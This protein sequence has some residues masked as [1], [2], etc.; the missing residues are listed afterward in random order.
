[1]KMKEDRG[2]QPG[3]TLA[4]EAGPATA[5]DP[6][7]E[8]IAQGLGASP[9]AKVKTGGLSSGEGGDWLYVLTLPQLKIAVRQD[10]LRAYVNLHS[11]AELGPE[12]VQVQLAQHHLQAVEIPS[13]ARLQRRAQGNQ[14]WVKVAEGR[15]PSP[16]RAEGVELGIPG[17]LVH[18]FWAEWL[19][20]FG[21]DLPTPET[22][23]QLQGLAVLPGQFLG[24][25]S[26]EQP[27]QAGTDVFGREVKPALEPMLCGPMPGAQVRRTEEGEYLAE[28][29]GYLAVVED[30]LTVLP[31]LSM[32]AAATQVWWVVLDQRPHPVEGELV[33]QGLADLGVTM[34]I[35][36]PAIKGLAAQ[37]REGTL[38]RGCYLIAQAIPPID[39]MDAR[40]EGLAAMER[41]AS[42][43][44]F[45]QTSAAPQ[46]RAGQ[47][48]ARRLPP[49]PPLLGYD[50]L[51]RPLPGREG[52]DHPL[53]AGRNVGLRF[54]EGAEE[55]VAQVE[56]RLKV[57]G[58]QVS[59][60]RLLVIRGDVGFDTGNLDFDGM[61]HV[62]GSVIQ[63][64]SVKAGS[65]LSI[66]GAV[67][68]GAE[69]VA[70]GRLWVGKGIV[71]RRT[72]VKAREDVYTQFVQE[73]TVMAGRDIVAHS[74]AHH[75]NL[76]AGGRVVVLRTL[77]KGGGGI[78]GGQAWSLE[79]M[80]LFQAGDTSNA[81]TLLV[82]GMRP[83]QAEQLDKLARHLETSSRHIA[84][85]LNKFGLLK[86]DM[87][88]IRNLITAS[89]GPRRKVLMT[90]VRHLAQVAQVHQKLLLE[91]RRLESQVGTA[92]D[93]VQIAVKEYAYPGVTVR[94]GEFSLKVAHALK[95]PCFHLDAGKLA[96]E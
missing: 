38:Q 70:L 21:Q 61:V 34:G 57:A 93:G 26:Q 54:R 62:E 37:L 82:G 50:V 17:D 94:L 81:S 86:I 18:C 91:S 35:D 92:I 78:A 44:D 60:E 23:D 59:V 27:G 5:A 85:L 39:E 45:C 65:D 25:A 4:Q 20:A 90:N 73:A 89:A 64:F 11:L 75:A 41:E 43:F 72:R 80:E 71:G 69:V 24:S 31:P 33:R 58:N 6:Q 10:G 3:A 53:V 30:Q 67:E 96:T 13:L 87:A 1:M 51:G 14:V 68:N 36:Q 46:V 55:W 22:L 16:G 32:D 79:G 95:A 42:A 88:Q 84:R 2:P 47:V 40:V 74:H 83:E 12:Q 66:A 15:P 77:E 9:L 76:R 19:A 7:A 49:V 52:K 56:G 29:Y 8:W 28:R 48:V 63:G